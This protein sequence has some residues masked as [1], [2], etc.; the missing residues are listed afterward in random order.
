MSFKKLHFPRLTY[1]LT[2]VLVCPFLIKLTEILRPKKIIV[3]TLYRVHT[4]R[5]VSLVFEI[6]RRN[7]NYY[8]YKHNNKTLMI[9]IYHIL[10]IHTCTLILGSQS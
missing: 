5:G 9:Y 4:F 3:I 10:F 8:Y 7:N 6:S 1:S 2:T